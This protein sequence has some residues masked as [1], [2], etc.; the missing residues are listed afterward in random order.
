MSDK[1][2]LEDLRE[3]REVLRAVGQRQLDL[4]KEVEA[5]I[6]QINA[7]LHRKS[8][9][10]RKWLYVRTNT[11]QHEG[12]KYGAKLRVQSVGR[13]W[14]KLIYRGRWFAFYPSQV[15]TDKPSESSLNN[16]FAK[17]LGGVR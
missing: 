9:R 16:N 4:L 3:G 11:W 14:V 7:R 2:R 1:T 12:V 17:I 13:K 6:S 15:A 5:E 8:I 10:S